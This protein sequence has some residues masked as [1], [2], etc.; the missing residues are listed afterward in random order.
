MSKTPLTDSEAV[1]SNCGTIVS[2][3]FARGLEERLH[4]AERIVQLVDMIDDLECNDDIFWNRDNIVNHEDGLF[5][6]CN[7]AFAWGC[8]DAE[9]LA[10]EDIPALREAHKDAGIGDG[11]LLFIA[12]KRKM[13]PQGA[14]Y[15]HIKKK[16]W[17]LFDAC[18]PARES[19][20]GN[21]VG[22][23][24]IEAYVLKKQE[25]KA[26]KSAP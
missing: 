8:A 10:V 17:P 18:G 25:E 24:Q 15:A 7:D 9:I 19:C 13:R 2:A 6:N 16:F 4:K 3:D 11:S 22:S 12:R 5:L 26:K 14:M 1:Q 21:P 20:F 23:D